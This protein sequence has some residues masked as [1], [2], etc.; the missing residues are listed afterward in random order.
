MTWMSSLF[1][2]VPP[3]MGLSQSEQRLLLAALRGGT[4]EDLSDELAISVSAVKKAWRSIYD[5][6]AEHLPGHILDGER[7]DG[8]RG[9]QKKQRLLAHLR[10]HPEELRPHSRKLLKHNT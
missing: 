7:E 3:K 1:M 9:K 6:A 10:S 8:E 2:H 4:D 5:R